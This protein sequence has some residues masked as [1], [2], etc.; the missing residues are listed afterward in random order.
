MSH[1]QNAGKYIAGITLLPLLLPRTSSDGALLVDNNNTYLTTTI[2][3]CE[4]NVF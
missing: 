1:S 2:F 3:I 4:Y